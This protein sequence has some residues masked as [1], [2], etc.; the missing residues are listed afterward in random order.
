MREQE[1]TDGFL[2]RVQALMRR[3]IPTD[4]FRHFRE[5]REMNRTLCRIEPLKFK[6]SYSAGGVLT[7]A[8]DGLI[9]DG[10][11]GDLL[12]IAGFTDT[13]T[14]QFGVDLALLTFNVSAR[15]ME[16]GIFSTD[17]DQLQ[18][19]SSLGPANPIYFKRGIYRF[20]PGS[21]VRVSYKLDGA[22]VGAARKFGVTLLISL[23]HQSFV[24]R[25]R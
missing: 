17:Q 7:Q 20:K 12:G 19:C 11:Y 1:I 23:I 16:S 3:G 6:A 14:T 13:N 9:P 15:G 4:R 10:F 21:T 2:S 18:Y 25:H 5:G 22:N 24:E 8:D